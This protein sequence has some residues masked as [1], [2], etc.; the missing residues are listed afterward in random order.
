MTKLLYFF[1]EM[2]TFKRSPAEA[3]YSPALLAALLIIDVLLTAVVN[4]GLKRPAQIDQTL[5]TDLT[6]MAALAGILSLRN[7][8]SRW[9]Q[10]SI[11][12]F[13][14]ALLINLLVFLL[15]IAYHLANAPQSG[16]V[17]GFFAISI[18][19]FFVWEIAILA[20]IL[21]FAANWTMAAALPAAIAMAVLVLAV[22]RYVAP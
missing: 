22:S 9:L 18:L 13:G 19:I 12:F 1:F 5:I 16:P 4:I 17:A 7:Q 11:S 8:S 14:A 2:L 6:V 3:P 20:H 15:A 21:R 10:A